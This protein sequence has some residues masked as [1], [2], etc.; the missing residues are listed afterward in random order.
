MSST[1]SAK[2]SPP[3]QTEFVREASSRPR[4][5]RTDLVTAP[6]FLLATRDSGY[7][8]SSLA[9]AELIDNSIQAQATTVDIVVNRTASTDH[10][11]EILVNDDGEGMDAS[12][13]A[14]ALS[15]GGSTRFDDRG[16]LGRYGMGLPN[17]GLSRARRIEVFSWRGDPVLYA[18]LDIDELIRSRRRSLPRVRIVPRPDFVP[19][20]KRGTTVVLTRCDRLEYR[21]ASS[22]IGRLKADLGRI[23]RHFLAGGFVLRLNGETI[24]AADPLCFSV[25][26]SQFG[27]TLEYRLL[28]PQGE[29]TVKVLFSELPIEQWHALGSDEKRRLG[30]TGAPAVSIVRADRE[31]DRGWFFMG[32]KRRE[33]YDDWWRCEIR[34]DPL[35]DEHF[36]IT[37]AKQAIRPSAELRAA[38]EPDLEAVGRA[39][40]RRARRRFEFLKVARPASAAVSQASKVYRRL[41]TL[42]TEYG[43]TSEPAADLTCL[44]AAQRDAKSPPY[45]IIVGELESADAFDFAV[46]DSRLSLVLNSRHPLYRDLYEPLASS[47]STADRDVAKRIAL[48]VLAAAHAEAVAAAPA[49][50]SSARLARSAWAD[51]VAAFFNA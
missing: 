49:D 41:P 42:P 17:G 26:A 6:N 27:E 46:V 24:P 39:L 33:N 18:C 13:L 15:F 5:P 22:L 31:V 9:V 1:P 35:L 44:S 16:S 45:D 34:F 30:V 19:R 10:P 43:P 29:G 3:G 25:G 20:S 51:V 47:E 38:L 4:T 7:K 12:T 2:R 8:S 37:N 21:R 36:G 40:N 23:Y 28:G 48:A 11:L 32:A 14:A 50:G